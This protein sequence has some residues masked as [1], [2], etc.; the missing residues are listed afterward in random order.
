MQGFIL[1]VKKVRDEDLLVTIITDKK[2]KTMYRFYGA[3]HSAINLGYKIDFASEGIQNRSLLRLRDVTH[4]GYR[5]LRDR[6]KLLA[7]QSFCMLLGEHLKGVEEHDGFYFDILE[8]CV[9]K[10]DKSSPKRA[11]LESYL[12][13]LRREG[14]FHDP[15]ECFFCSS[16][17]DATGKIALAR[18]FLP[19]HEGCIFQ[20][21]FDGA[22]LLDFFKTGSTMSLNDAEIEALYGVMLLGF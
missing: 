19:S 20:P 5:W 21:G 16:P 9:E 1:G 12:L 18:G 2:I 4:I 17:L 11:L 10:L 8:K 22:K 3:R 14:R 7:W 13:L 15:R 6:G